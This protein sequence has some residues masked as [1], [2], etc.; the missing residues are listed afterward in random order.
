M[1]MTTTTTCDSLLPAIAASTRRGLKQWKEKKVERVLNKWRKFNEKT[2]KLRIENQDGGWLKNRHCF[3][4]NRILS[5]P[6]PVHTVNRS[7]K[8]DDNLQRKFSLQDRGSAPKIENFRIL[9]CLR[10]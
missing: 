5:R 2:Q 7:V 9:W 6:G 4:S 3:I 10:R 8:E 1:T